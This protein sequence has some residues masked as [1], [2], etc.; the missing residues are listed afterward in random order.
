MTRNREGYKNVSKA[1]VAPEVAG[2]TD[3]EK[4]TV[5]NK[6]TQKRGVRCCS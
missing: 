6:Q 2:V 1:A 4:A 5:C 3:E